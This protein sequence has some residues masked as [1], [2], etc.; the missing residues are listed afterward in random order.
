M[1]SCVAGFVDA[2]ETLFDCVQRE[3][4]E[5]V[6]VEI[7]GGLGIQVSSMLNSFLRHSR[8]QIS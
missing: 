5:E 2:G 3:V 7:I 1:F 4:A 6:S 8:G